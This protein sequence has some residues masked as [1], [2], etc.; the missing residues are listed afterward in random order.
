MND[1]VIDRP[2]VLFAIQYPH[3]IWGIFAF[4]ETSRPSPEAIRKPSSSEKSWRQVI[5][6]LKGLCRDCELCRDIVL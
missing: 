4:C 1:I 5:L 6:S 3:V 2:P